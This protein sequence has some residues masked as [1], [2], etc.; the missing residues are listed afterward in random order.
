MAYALPQNGVRVVS[1]WRT[2][3]FFVAYALHL[4]GDPRPLRGARVGSAGLTRDLC[5]A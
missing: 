2:R 5:M 4:W 1:S 3:G